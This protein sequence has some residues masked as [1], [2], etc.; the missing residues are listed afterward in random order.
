MNTPT[1]IEITREHNPFLR[2]GIRT[3]ADGIPRYEG[4]PG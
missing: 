4:L 1:I 3:G 2:D